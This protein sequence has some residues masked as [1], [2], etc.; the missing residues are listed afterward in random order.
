MGINDIGKEVLI[1]LENLSKKYGNSHIFSNLTAEIRKGDFICV[2]GPSGSGKTTLIR[3]LLGVE[4][5]S[6]GFIYQENDGVRFTYIP[7][8]PT[9]LPWRSTIENVMSGM[10]G[11]HNSQKS[12]A[13]EMLELVGL[14]GKEDALPR[15][16]SGGMQQRVSFARAL[17]SDPDI[18]FMDEPFSALDEMRR[19]EL[20]ALVFDL[21]QTSGVTFVMNTHSIEDASILSTKV[22]VMSHTGARGEGAT[23]QVLDTWQRTESLESRKASTDR[24]AIRVS[25]EQE[26]T[27]AAA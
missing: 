13:A 6:S 1:K 8:Q 23:L 22:W 11:R 26:I 3:C 12:K 10:V 4:K 2:V 16:L 27:Q 5:I 20:G 9:L 7:Q 17:V 19:V 25:I 24:A 18:V 21:W 15:Q 14:S